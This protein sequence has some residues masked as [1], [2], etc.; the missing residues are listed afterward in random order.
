MRGNFLIFLLI[1]IT[2]YLIVG[3]VFTMMMRL[4]FGIAIFLFILYVIYDKK[5]R[6]GEKVERF[7]PLTLYRRNKKERTYKKLKKVWSAIQERYGSDMRC[8]SCGGEITV[9]TIDIDGRCS[10]CGKRLV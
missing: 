4:G 10:L 9:F 6:I 8:P 2:I 3:M 7:N 1:L 5:D